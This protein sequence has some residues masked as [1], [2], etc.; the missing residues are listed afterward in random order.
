[1]THKKIPTIIAMQRIISILNECC[2]TSETNNK[3][4]LDILAYSVAKRS[5]QNEVLVSIYR[6]YDFT[7]FSIVSNDTYAQL[8]V[9]DL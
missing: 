3:E 1:M 5:K 2:V 9:F 7:F 4:I 6:E 8:Y